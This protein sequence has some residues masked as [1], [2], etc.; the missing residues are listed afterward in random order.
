MLVEG[1]GRGSDDERR[2]T[3]SGQ[4]VLHG[5]KWQVQ[6]YNGSNA[7][8][9]SHPWGSTLTFR[10]NAGVSWVLGLRHGV[11][12]HPR[13]RHLRGGRTLLLTWRSHTLEREQQPP[14]EGGEAI[15]SQ[16]PSEQGKGDKGERRGVKTMPLSAGPSRPT[17]GNLGSNHNSNE[18]NVSSREASQVSSIAFTQQS[19][20]RGGGKC[21]S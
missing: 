3:G 1:G 11:T 12:M 5:Y 20:S 16:R 13:G 14:E 8:Q 17:S 18:Q 9:L 4:Q 21:D 15:T 10:R 6:G 2:T 7:A 19:T